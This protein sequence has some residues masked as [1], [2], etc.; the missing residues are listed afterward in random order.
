MNP[1]KLIKMDESLKGMILLL[2]VTGIVLI[3]TNHS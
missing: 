1:L 3:V 2:S